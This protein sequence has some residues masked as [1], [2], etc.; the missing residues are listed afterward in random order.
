ME[1][2]V[3]RI[4]EN[5]AILEQTITKEKRE[6]DITT[7]PFSLHEGSILIFEKGNYILEEE[8]ENKR[9]KEI[10]ERFKKLRKQTY[11]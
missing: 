1:W 11:Q 5:I 6:I 4:E 7:L 10:E 3:D 8:K 9:R 2:I